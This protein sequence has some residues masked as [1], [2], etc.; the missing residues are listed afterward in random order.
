MLS[1]FFLKIPLILQL[2]SK[3]CLLTGVNFDLKC[4]NLLLEKNNHSIAFQES[5]SQESIPF[6]R[7]SVKIIALTPGEL[8]FCISEEMTNTSEI[9]DKDFGQNF[10]FRT[11]VS[12]SDKM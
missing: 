2:K 4:S 12:I 8:P 9:S 1:S 6:Y 7:K 11:K 5:I 10:P 3:T